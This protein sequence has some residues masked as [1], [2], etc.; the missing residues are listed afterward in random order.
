M[1]PLRD[2]NPGR[3]IPWATWLICGV[4]AAVF[5]A[6][7]G[8]FD[9]VPWALVPSE[10]LAPHALPKWTTHQFLHGGFLHL[11]GNLSYL[12]IFGNNIEDRMG[13]GRFLV[14]HLLCGYLAAAA[15]VVFDSASHIPML[16][17]SGAISGVLGAYLVLYPKVPVHGYL[18]G[19]IPVRLPAW[20]MLAFWFGWQL[21]AGG[22]SMVLSDARSGGGVA[23]A[24]HIGGFVAGLI[25]HRFFLIRRVARW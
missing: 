15:H 21:L 23:Y 4:C 11:A 19:W 9:P 7:I 10:G 6:E 18:F 8:G 2:D 17:A 22:A 3:N 1:I 16:G 25:L 20:T 5:V 12:F 14:F 24:A 13:P